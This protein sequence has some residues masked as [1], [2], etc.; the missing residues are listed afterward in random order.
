MQHTFTFRKVV[1]LLRIVPV[2][3]LLLGLFAGKASAQCTWATSTPYPSGTLDA[4]TATVGTNLYVFG[5]VAGGAITSASSKFDGTTWTSIAPVPAA[6]EYSSAVSDGTN[7]FIM[8]GALTGTG[9]PQTTNYRYNVATNTYTTLAPFSVGSWNHAAVFLNGKIYKFAGSNAGG[10]TNAL[11]IYDIATNTWTLGAVYPLSIAFVGSA[12]LN[13]F[14]YGAGGINTAGSAKTYRYDPVANVWD[15]AAIADL[16]VTRWGSASSNYRQGFVMAGGYAGGDATASISTSV[17]TWN[18]LTNTWTSLPNLIGERS[19]MTGSILNDKL[20]VIGGRSIASAAFLGT[21][22]NQELTCAPIVACTGTPTPGN[23]FASATAVCS[24]TSVTFT[25][26]NSTGGSGVTYQWQTSP[27][28]GGTYTNAPGTSTNPSYTTTVTTTAFYRVQVT[29]A[30]NSGTSTPVQVTVTPCT[31]L[32]PD[33]ATI[34]E[35]VIQRLSVTGTGT[36]G[37]STVPSGPIAIVIPDNTP[38]GISTTLPVSLPAGASVTSMNV[39]FNINHTWD[40]DVSINLIA[41]NGASLN[42]VNNRGG[43]GDDFI[44][45]TVSSTGTTTFAPPSA[46]PFTGTFAPDAAIGAGPTT[47]PSTATGFAALMAG[48]PSGDWRLALRDGA[49]GDIGTLTSWTLNFN[50]SVLPTATW[51]GGTIFSNAAAT[52][53]YVAGT[54]ANAVW[55]RPSTTTT[56]TANIASGP[57]A[58]NNDV[59][60]TVLPRPVV[61]VTPAVSC[62]PSTLTATGASTYT[63]TPSTGLNTTTGPT[64]T[65]NPTSTTTYTVT[66]TGANGCVGV[67]ATALVNS[68][69]VASVISANTPAPTFQINEAFSGATQPPTGWT[70]QNNSSAPL[71]TNWFKPTGT[72]PFPAFSGPPTA[73]I[74]ANFQS[75]TSAVGNETL[76]NWLLTPVVTLNNGDQLSFYTRTTDGTFPDRLEVRLSTNGASGNVGTTTTSVGDFTTV[77]VTVNPNLTTT[78]Y[79]LTWTR[80]TAT[81]TGLPATTTGR[82]G[83]RYF[84]T[85]GGPNGANSDYIGLDD[86][87]YFTNNSVNCANVT[88]SINVNITGGVGPYTVVYSNGNTNTTINTYTSGDPIQVSPNV[89]TSYTIVS[90]TGANG[91]VGTGNSGTATITITPPAKITTQPLSVSV[92]NGNTATF[93]VAST[94]LTGNNFQWQLSTDLGT[95]FTNLTNTA[96]YSGV[97]TSTLTITGATTAMSGYRYRVIA[98]GVCG[99]PDTSTVAVLTVNTAAVITAQPVSTSICSTPSTAAN[100]TTFSVA[101]TG[102]NLTYQWQVST[103]GGTSFTNVTNNANYTGA[104]TNTLTVRATNSTFNNYIYR[105]LVTSGGCTAVTSSTATLTVNPAPSVVLSAAPF[106][107]LFPGLQTT[108]T[109]AVSPNPVATYMWFRDGVLIPGVTGNSLPGLGVD[110]FGT[111]TVRV[112]DNQGCGGVSNAI[113]LR[114]SANS[115]LFIYPSP[116]N[117]QFSVRIFNPAGNTL[118]A[119][120]RQVVIYDSRGARVYS[121]LFTM[122]GAYVDMKVNL[123][124]HGK[125]I[126]SVDV[127]TNN[128]ERIKTGRVAVF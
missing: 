37:T 59:T 64:V 55:V 32:T 34:C 94:P 97:T 35:G 81:I 22:T 80:F 89:T 68:A 27:T 9:V 11:E 104:T 119:T 21:N 49:G 85:N 46:P 38:A 91:C 63:W 83:F 50:Y 20:Y 53:P 1:N 57:C 124:N 52:T 29:C 33:A 117:G 127:L 86:V 39:N 15:D 88:T 121:Q 23:T 65:A 115:N 123:A 6:L 114:D 13:G 95:T 110:D 18:P 48:N 56:Y 8:G 77:L 30:A 47:Y 122:V 74:A 113:T 4:P 60:V 14:I 79:P 107:A 62:G 93:T 111:Y 98:R 112:V 26:Q 92:C 102:G 71:G 105:V 42:L 108:L 70:L 16:P 66:G 106:T 28:A 116:N 76:S 51:T 109:V 84:V 82:V 103:N 25:S 96:P 41:P 10:Q 72:P 73:F 45:T 69:P 87:Q 90:I 44:N 5:G 67:P 128:G 126:Y 120:P 75:T 2:L 17:I 19:R 31:C 99:N 24:G 7:I 12:T 43:S 36:A 78:G 100:T 61:S 101:A 125:G 40:G 118:A 58:G 54:Q 3:M